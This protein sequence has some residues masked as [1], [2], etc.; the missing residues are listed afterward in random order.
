[1]ADYNVILGTNTADGLIVSNTSGDDSL[2]LLAGNDTV[3][4]SGGTDIVSLGS[5]N[6]LV[7]QPGDYS[8]GSIFGGEGNDTI[9]VNAKFN[10]S[11][12]DLE[13]PTTRSHW[14]R[15]VQRLA[16]PFLVV[17]LTTPLVSFLRFF[18]LL[19]TAVP[20]PFSPPTVMTASL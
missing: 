6:D 16:L 9:Q 12:I 1:M 13:A 5:G 14:P 15:P 4:G 7:T 20:P 19:S 3:T 18:P 11:I 10:G 8:A 17:L 2:A